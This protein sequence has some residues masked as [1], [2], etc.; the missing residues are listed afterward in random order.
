[1][2]KIKYDWEEIKREYLQSNEGSL[3]KFFGGKFPEIPQKTYE[4]NTKGWRDEK[5]KL[6]SNITQES[7]KIIE[8][9]PDLIFAHEKLLQQKIAILTLINNKLASEQQKIQFKDLKIAID[10]IKRELGEP[11]NHSLVGK[12][13][14]S[15]ESLEEVLEKFGVPKDNSTLKVEFTSFKK[16]KQ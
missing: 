4:K 7:K 12:D 9:N 14:N 1:M 13:E 10:I 5:K 6:F 8:K 2:P 11:L 15:A 16:Q 3:K